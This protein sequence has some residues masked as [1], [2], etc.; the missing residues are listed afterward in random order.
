[1]SLLSLLLQNPRITQCSFNW[2]WTTFLYDLNV[3]D[4]EL[5]KSGCHLGHV[6]TRV[7]FQLQAKLFPIAW[8]QSYKNSVKKWMWLLRLI[9]LVK[10][11]STVGP[12]SILKLVPNFKIEYLKNYKNYNR[13]ILDFRSLCRVKT[14]IATVHNVQKV[15]MEFSHQKMFLP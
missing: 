8:T 9:C 3:N 5:K 10:K 11:G 6:K 7:R 2:R 1:M 15:K 12:F 13:I 4:W 14:Y